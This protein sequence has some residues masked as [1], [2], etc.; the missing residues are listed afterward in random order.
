MRYFVPK[1]LLFEACKH[2][3][4]KESAEDLVKWINNLDPSRRAEIRLDNDR[5]I[6]DTYYVIYDEE[7]G[8]EFVMPGTRVVW[9]GNGSFGLYDEAEFNDLFQPASEERLVEEGLMLV[10]PS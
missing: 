6:E 2:D 7:S 8:D 9:M 3:G 4:T 10:T 1:Q 5:R